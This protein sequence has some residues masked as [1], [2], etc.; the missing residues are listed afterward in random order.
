MGGREQM[1]QVDLDRVFAGKDADFLI[2]R[3]DIINV[4][5][6]PF[7]PFLRSLRD[8]SIPNPVSNI[9]YSFTYARNFADIDSFAV[10]QNPAN[11]PREIPS[12]FP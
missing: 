12:L 7:A 1:V 9:G 10:Q 2:R 3:G 4:G 11:R 8:L 6:H 5:T